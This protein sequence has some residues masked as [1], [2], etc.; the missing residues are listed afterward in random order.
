MN[1]INWKELRKLVDART[2][3]ERVALI[4]AVV[5]VIAYTWLVFVFDVL[6]AGQEENARLINNTVN[7]I[8]S[9]LTRNQNIRDSYT[10][11]PNAFIRTRITALEQDL[12]EVD[13]TLLNLYGELI[14]PQQ[15]AGVLTEILQGETTLRLISFENLE[16][17]SLMD[18]EEA[19]LQGFDDEQINVYR[20]G[21]RMVFEGDY[22]ETIRFLRRV[23]GLDTSFF[24]DNLDFEVIEYPRASITLNIFTLSTQRGFIGV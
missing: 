11:D 21:L 12:R 16:P 22:L 8:N 17:E 10:R 23:E 20:H 24:W 15:M 13:S 6:D 18:D 2:L 5:V 19:Q 1:R 4:L 9:E 7:Q 3:R 14:L